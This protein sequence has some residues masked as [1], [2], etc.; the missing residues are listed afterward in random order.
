MD[1]SKKVITFTASGSEIP[2]RISDKL[3]HGRLRVFAKRD[4]SPLVPGRKYYVLQILFIFQISK[5]SRT[6]SGREQKNST[7]SSINKTTMRKSGT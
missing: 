4:Q 2:W 6:V 1:E 7:Y 5:Y 3:K